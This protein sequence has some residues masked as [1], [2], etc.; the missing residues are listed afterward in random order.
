MTLITRPSRAGPAAR[1]SIVST[2]GMIMPPP[3]P[4]TTRNAMSI[5]MFWAAPVRP[6]PMT[7]SVTAA[8]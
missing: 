5:S 6:E 7:N 8:M 2:S 3:R 1:V 4:W